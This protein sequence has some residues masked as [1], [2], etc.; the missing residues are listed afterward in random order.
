MLSRK[1]NPQMCRSETNELVASKREVSCALLS[2]KM[3]FRHT[4]LARELSRGSVLEQDRRK[5]K[6]QEHPERKTTPK[7]QPRVLQEV[8]KV[9]QWLVAQMP[10]ASPHLNDLDTNLPKEFNR[11]GHP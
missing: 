11:V 9:F 8:L 5:S 4:R 3:R 10:Q 1:K 2:K 7:N 6:T